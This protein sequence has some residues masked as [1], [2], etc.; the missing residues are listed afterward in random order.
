VLKGFDPVFGSI[1]K[2]FIHPQSWIA[3]TSSYIFFFQLQILNMASATAL[4]GLEAVV[5]LRGST[6]GHAA[7]LK[8]IQYSVRLVLGLTARFSNGGR[9]DADVPGSDDDDNNS[10][11]ADG[12]DDDESSAGSDVPIHHAFE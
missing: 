11:S 7:V 4:R 8:T 1:E 10:N 5:A 6:K 9:S 3:E 12:S 2:S